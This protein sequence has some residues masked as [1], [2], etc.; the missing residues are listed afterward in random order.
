MQFLQLG[1]MQAHRSALAALKESNKGQWDDKEQ[2]HTMMG[3]VEV[4]NTEHAID[5]EL[6]TMEDHEIAVWGY[7]MMQY[8]LKAGLQKIGNKGAKAA[9]TELTQLHMMNTWS[10]MD[11]FKL[12]K[13]DRAR[14]SVLTTIPEGK[15]MW[16]DQRLSMSQW[17]APEGVHPKRGGGVAYR[18]N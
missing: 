17:G 5:R 8:N 13:E 3:V 2:M 12:S 15:E 16:E 10:V 14:E 6:T 11:P 4:D 18:I 1:K 9:V 7:L